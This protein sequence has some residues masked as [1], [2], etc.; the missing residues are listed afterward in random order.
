MAW[1]LDWDNNDSKSPFVDYEKFYDFPEIEV[2][3]SMTL[4]REVI[5]DKFYLMNGIK[6]LPDLV[7]MR[8]GYWIASAE[9][10][11]FLE[12]NAPGDCDF[13]PIELWRNKKSASRRRVFDAESRLEKPYYFV[14]I[15]HRLEAVDWEHS[16]AK[17]SEGMGYELTANE[18]SWVKRVK[19]P[20]GP[21]VPYIYSRGGGVTIRK[22]VIAGHHMWKD[23]FN[24]AG[25]VWCTFFSNSLKDKIITKKMVRAMCIPV[26]EI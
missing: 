14:R 20:S 25:H 10:K 18:K 2:F 5:P 6:N 8:H 3:R 7:V 4:P 19:F 17:F 16:E 24:G 26:Q 9:G 21:D 11:A 15:L 22:S 12:E 23:N 1:I 13:V